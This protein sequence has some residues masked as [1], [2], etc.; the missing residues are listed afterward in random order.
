MNQSQVT[1][2]LP[3]AGQ[4]S[5]LGLETPKELFEIFPGTHLIDYSLDHIL[6]YIRTQAEDTISNITLT[7]VTR[8]WKKEISHYVQ[9]RL[10]RITHKEVMFNE[11]Y[12]EWPGSVFSAQ[13]TFSL[14]NIV[15]LPDSFIGLNTHP[16]APF[17]QSPHQETLILSMI[18]A[19]QNH[20]VVFGCIPCT[21]PQRLKSLGALRIENNIITRFQDKPSHNVEDF[22]GFW[23]C[24]GFRKEYAESLYRFLIAS[25][26]HQPISLEDQPFYPPALVLIQSY[27]DLGTWTNIEDFKKSFTQKPPYH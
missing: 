6:Q 16:S 2:I 17:T 27:H 25:V 20:P 14:Y 24:Y 18:N 7:V 23:G 4:G 1:I 10:P 3:C 12:Q 8:P 26:K 11:N 9:S 13:E 21:N 15:L 19:L 5:R 22:N